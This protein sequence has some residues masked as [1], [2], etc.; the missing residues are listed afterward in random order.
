MAHTLSKEQEQHLEYHNS[1]G[2]LAV[3]TRGVEAL[4]AAIT[5]YM[6]N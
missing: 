4:K 3:S 2:N 5:A 1:I 6:D